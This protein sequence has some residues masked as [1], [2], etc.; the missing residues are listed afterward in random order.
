MHSIFSQQ[1]F[2]VIFVAITIYYNCKFIQTIF[3]IP[4]GEG[5]GVCGAP[6]QGGVR[7]PEGAPQAQG[8]RATNSYRTSQIHQV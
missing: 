6:E 8:C 5:A 4:A 3:F 1:L 7:P 2:Q